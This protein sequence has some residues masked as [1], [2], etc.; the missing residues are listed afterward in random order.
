MR[1]NTTD[2]QRAI[3]QVRHIRVPLAEFE[4][5][6]DP[7]WKHDGEIDPN[8]L[9]AGGFPVVVL[10]RILD[11]LAQQ[12]QSNKH[13]FSSEVLEEMARDLRGSF[14]SLSRKE[15][16]RIILQGATYLSRLRLS[17]NVG[18]QLLRK[19]VNNLG[20]TV[21][22]IHVARPDL[23]PEEILGE[24][25]QTQLGI[26][27]VVPEFWLIWR[28]SLF[29]EFWTK[30]QAGESIDNFSNTFLRDVQ[31][32]LTYYL[33][34]TQLIRDAKNLSQ[35]ET[36]NIFKVEWEADLGYALAWIIEQEA[37]QVTVNVNLDLFVNTG[38]V[39]TI[40]VA[41]YEIALS[42]RQKSALK[43]L[44]QSA[45]YGEDQEQCSLVSRDSYSRAFLNWNP[46]KG[47]GLWFENNVSLMLPGVIPVRERLLGV[48]NPDAFC[49]NYARTKKVHFA[50]PSES[51]LLL[52]NI[53]NAKAATLAIYEEMEKRLECG[54]QHPPS[55]IITDFEMFGDRQ[56][57]KSDNLVIKEGGRCSAGGNDV[58]LVQTRQYK[59]AVLQRPVASK[60]FC[61]EQKNLHGHVRCLSVLNSRGKVH[62]LGFVIKLSTKASENSSAYL[63]FRLLF[64]SKGNFMYGSQ[65]V[66]Q[67]VIY[68]TDL[69]LYGLQWILDKKEQKKLFEASFRNWLVSMLYLNEFWSDHPQERIEQLNKKGLFESGVLPLET[70]NL[71]VVEKTELQ[72]AT[73][74]LMAA[75]F[76]RPMRGK[77][78]TKGAIWQPQPPR[79]KTL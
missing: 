45:Q 70:R 43:R 1:W 27:R 20:E 3:Q 24:L 48:C 78:Y 33:D 5:L 2:L 50:V 39:S 65:V 9:S 17:E 79:I 56:L 23:K 21:E 34:A 57:L 77:K 6:Y 61:F 19:W 12:R 41:A 22:T 16:Q 47:A 62:H 44:L 26:C 8:V 73:S 30:T 14:P 31:K 51:Y 42:K 10:R 28:K 46:Q 64:D 67:D 13:T 7:E 15:S 49:W 69:R 76:L 53:M 63:S 74:Q 58:E 29:A 11:T 54:H 18:H 68:F 37:P 25:T 36:I 75:S 55:K 38:F 71:Q 4:Y 72:R 60:L 32:F 35:G 66:S 59:V 40:P 52:A